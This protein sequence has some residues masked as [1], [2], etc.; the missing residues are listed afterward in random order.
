MQVMPPSKVEKLPFGQVAGD[1]EVVEGVFFVLVADQVDEVE[2]G[3][4]VPSGPGPV[5]EDAHDKQGRT[6]DE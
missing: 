3:E 4:H 5:G 6:Q 1:L 2:A